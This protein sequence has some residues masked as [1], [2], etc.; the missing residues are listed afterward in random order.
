MRA[1]VFSLSLSLLACGSTPPPEPATPTSL[2]AAARGALQIGT[3][4]GGAAFVPRLETLDGG[5]CADRAAALRSRLL[6]LE[7]LYEGVPQL[8]R[9]PGSIPE[10]LPSASNAPSEEFASVIYDAAVGV[11][12]DGVAS[13]LDALAGATSVLVRADRHADGEAV[14]DALRTLRDGG[15]HTVGLL[16]ARPFGVGL[17][18]APAPAV[19]EGSTNADVVFASCPI[20]WSYVHKASPEKKAELW[21]ETAV[22]AVEDCDCA[23][24]PKEVSWLRRAKHEDTRAIAL[25]IDVRGTSGSR[26]LVIRAGGTWGPA[27]RAL[28]NAIRIDPRR[29]RGTPVVIDLDGSSTTPTFIPGN[30]A[31]KVTP[32]DPTER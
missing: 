15:V 4:L 14:R 23:A 24:D 8:V 12:K 6:A 7:L 11:S 17:D 22:A 31:P 32:P 16:Y 9:S 13:G 3:A 10:T 20:D 30:V 18:E 25:A 5:L 26:P 28:Y 2:A 1:L 19:P 21:I 27:S 29:P